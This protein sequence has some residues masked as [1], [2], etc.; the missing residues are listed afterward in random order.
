V[1][2]GQFDAGEFG[3]AVEVDGGH[4]ADPVASKAL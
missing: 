1:L 3:E 2:G 4:T